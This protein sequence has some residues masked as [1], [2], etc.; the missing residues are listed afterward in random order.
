MDLLGLG[1]ESEGPEPQ[2]GVVGEAQFGGV[3]AQ[4]EVVAGVL[5]EGAHAAVEAVGVAGLAEAHFVEEVLALDVVELLLA[6]EVGR[7]GPAEAV[8]CDS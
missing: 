5:E 7:G 3:D 4:P 1:F 2:G 8:F 6:V